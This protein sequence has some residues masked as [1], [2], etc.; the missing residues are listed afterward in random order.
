[1]SDVATTQSV[2]MGIRYY[3]YP[4][5]AEDIERARLDPWLYLSDDP[6]SDAWGPAELRPRMLYLDKCWRA[7]QH[8]LGPRE[9]RPARPSF[10]LVEGQVTFAGNGGWYS[11]LRV[12]DPE[13]LT[14]IARDIVLVDEDDVRELFPAQPGEMQRD[15]VDYVAPYLADAQR[16]VTELAREGKGLVYTIG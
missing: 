9:D 7:L 10:A 3:A 1:M 12:I 8:L 14:E 2:W 4:V 15:T 13:Q 5:A 6:L 11:W 16:F